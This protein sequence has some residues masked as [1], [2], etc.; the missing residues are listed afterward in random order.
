MKQKIS[1]CASA[2]GIT[3]AKTSVNNMI[4]SGDILLWDGVN[5]SET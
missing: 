3:L 1:N 2:K 5:K 4:C